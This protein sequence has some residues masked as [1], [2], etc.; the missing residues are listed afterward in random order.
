MIKLIKT[1]CLYNMAI[2]SKKDQSPFMSSI[3]LNDV[4]SDLDGYR[5]RVA[6]IPRGK[7]TQL[8]KCLDCLK[9]IS[10]TAIGAKLLREIQASG[11]QVDIHIND[12]GK[13]C[14]HRKDISVDFD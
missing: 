11:K 8:F 5:E 7:D 6:R 3:Q 2:I 9:E 1:N 4:L 10:N 12:K 14:V 13:S